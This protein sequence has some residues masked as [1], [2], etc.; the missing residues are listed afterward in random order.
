MSIANKAFAWLLFAAGGTLTALLF[1]VLIALFLLVSMGEVPSGLEY[2]A[3]HGFA[4]SIIGGTV[5]FIV[6]SLSAWHAAHRM[7][8]LAHDLGIRAD[9]AVALAVYSL[10]LIATVGAA[11]LLIVIRSAGS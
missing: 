1:P 2:G 7:R 3:I 5:L 10:A 9:R 11:V 4:G 8:V 6:V